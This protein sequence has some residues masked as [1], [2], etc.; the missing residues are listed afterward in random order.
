MWKLIQQEPVMF[1][2]MI[3]ALFALAVA[4]GLNL[5]AGQVGA[6]L[7]ASAAILSFLTR[8]Q[9]TPT[10]NPRASDGTPLVRSDAPR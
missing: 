1:Q 9:V 2:G 7:A 6:I 4:F 10:I 8:T 3:Q 5:S